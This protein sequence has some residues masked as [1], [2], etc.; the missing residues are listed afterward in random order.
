MDSYS[1]NFRIKNRWVRTASIVLVTAMIVAPITAYAAD[2]FTDVPNTNTFHND[3][4]WLADADVT[5]GCNPPAN[6]QYCPSD[7]VTRGQMAA[8]L[9]RLAEN[10]VVDAGAL[11]GDAKSTFQ[12]WGDTL[13]HGESLTGAWVIGGDTGF[14][15]EGIT[16]S[17]PLPGDI[18]LSDAHYLPEGAAF[19]VDCPGI[20]QAAIGH[21]CV[22]EISSSFTGTFQCF[23]DPSTGGL[24]VRSY[25]TSFFLDFD[26]NEGWAFGSWTVTSS[27]SLTTLS[28]QGAPNTNATEPGA[29]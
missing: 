3:I 9:R 8:F 2:R 6:T 20:G 14:P 26:A 16:F 5:K 27:S 4:S 17:T 13:P 28:T 1:V 10:Q 23:C 19:T 25:G 15:G 22:Y 29:Q 21:L 18:P 11:E 24:G 12:Q 7:N